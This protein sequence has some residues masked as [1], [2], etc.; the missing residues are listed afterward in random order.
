MCRAEA[1]AGEDNVF[2]WQCA[3]ASDRSGRTGSAASG[4][5]KVADGKAR[6][7]GI[8]QRG[9]RKARRRL[10][11]WTVVVYVRAEACLSDGCGAAVWF[12]GAR[13]TCSSI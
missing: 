3:R 10:W 8:G 1:P 5:G 12:A 11:G 7:G 4:G 2:D 6:V 13:G 9:G